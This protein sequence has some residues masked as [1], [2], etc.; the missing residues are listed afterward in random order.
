MSTYYT[1]INISAEDVYDLLSGKDK[2][3]FNKA[4]I[5]DVTR[6]SDMSVSITVALVNDIPL[7]E[8]VMDSAVEEV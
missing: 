8:M 4:I 1:H 2:Q 5:T 6:E 7:E 3:R